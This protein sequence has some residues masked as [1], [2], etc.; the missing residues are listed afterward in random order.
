MIKKAKEFNNKQFKIEH[1]KIKKE[2][3]GL[4]RSVHGKANAWI[5]KGRQCIQPEKMCEWE[6][7]VK[8]GLNE[9]FSEKDLAVSLMLVEALNHGT[10]D[11]AK[12]IFDYRNIASQSYRM[13]KVLVQVFC[14]KGT[15]FFNAIEA[16]NGKVLN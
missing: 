5:E 11:N 1:K 14:D 6:K 15:D 16:E 9:M 10:F 4:K 8:L 12:T 3:A 2:I 7:C 13:I